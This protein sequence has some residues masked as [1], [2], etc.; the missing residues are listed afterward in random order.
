MRIVYVLESD[1]NTRSQDLRLA[2]SEDA[3]CMMSLMHYVV[4]EGY[5]LWKR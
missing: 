5:F 4:E 2:L 3:I 1:K